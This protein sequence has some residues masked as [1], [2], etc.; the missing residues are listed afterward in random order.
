VKPLVLVTFDQF[1]TLL[2][3]IR[4]KFKGL[5]G[6]NP[7]EEYY[8]TIG[9]VIPSFPGHPRFRPRFLGTSSSKEM[10]EKMVV[11]APG[12]RVSLI[13]SEHDRNSPFHD[14][15]EICEEE[16]PEG[17]N[18]ENDAS[19]EQLKNKLPEARAIA[20]K[21]FDKVYNLN[22]AKGKGCKTDTYG[23]SDR[24]VFLD[25]A[26]KQLLNAQRYLGLQPA[27]TKTSKR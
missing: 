19:G 21:I 9:L 26:E 13:G 16:I 6:T 3:Q 5:Q 2:K 12:P 1:A 14:R 25:S 11:K 24:I 15:N 27:P 7:D 22:K 20:T 18:L 23:A 17:E 8:T 10:Y 4:D